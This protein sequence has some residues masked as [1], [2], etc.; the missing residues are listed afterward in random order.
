[1][2][3]LVLIIFMELAGVSGFAQSGTCGEN[4]TW[5]LEDGT[6]TIRGVGAMT[7]FLSDGSPWNSYRNDITTIVVEPGVERIGN[8]AFYRC[9]YLASIELPASVTSIGEWAFCGCYG[10]T[11]IAIPASVT[12]IGTAAFIYCSGLASITLPDAVTSIENAVF[13]ECYNLASI[14]LPKAVTSIG[15]YAFLYCS[16]LASITLPKTVTSIGT[17]AFYGCVGL[18]DL[19]VNWNPAADPTVLWPTINSMAFSGL[20]LSGITLHVPA[21]ERAAYEQAEIW[22]EFNI[23]EQPP[24]GIPT[25]SQAGGLV[26]Y[27]QD[28]VLHVSGLAAGE[29]LGVYDASGKRIRRQIAGGEAARVPLAVRGVYIIRAE[30]RSV[31][32]VY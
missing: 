17:A 1:M 4:L 27:V 10:L 2:K 23:V 15:T 22:K 32:V 6:L 21:G 24:V 7:D 14:T 25:V 9:E 20:T 29:A 18:T 30:N 13:R 28:G 12:A 16:S 31:R 5:E 26:A 8:Y 11:S 19:T 3:Q